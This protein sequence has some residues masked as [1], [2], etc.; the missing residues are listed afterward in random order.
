M[1][2]LPFLN[3]RDNRAPLAQWRQ[4]CP[5][6]LGQILSKAGERSLHFLTFSAFLNGAP[7]AHS[8]GASACHCNHFAYILHTT[9]DC[10]RSFCMVKSR[11]L[12]HLAALG[13]ASMMLPCNV[14]LRDCLNCRIGRPYRMQDRQLWGDKTC[15]MSWKADYHHSDYYHSDS[16]CSI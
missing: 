8:F 15:P 13:L 7:D 5:E 10:L 6:T 4:R 2:G 3:C 12:A 14:A 16:V 1:Q 11:G 9:M